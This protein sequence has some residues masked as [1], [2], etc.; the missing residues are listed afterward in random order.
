M[1][2]RETIQLLNCSCIFFNFSVKTHGLFRQICLKRLILSKLIK[3]L[4]FNHLLS[5]IIGILKINQIWLTT[6]LFVHSLPSIFVLFVF[7]F[8]SILFR[9]AWWP[10]SGKKLS[11]WLSACAVYILCRQNCMCSIA[12]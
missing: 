5:Q 8:A 3:S 4:V 1:N 2:S 11:S 9:K 10:P 6:S 7:D 12:A